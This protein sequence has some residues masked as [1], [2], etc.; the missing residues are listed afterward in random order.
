MIQLL[1]TVLR[2]L[3]A[4]AL[5][6]VGSILLTALAVGSAVLGPIFAE[7]VT[8]SYVV[9]P[10]AR[11]PGRVHRADP[12]ARAP[13]AVAPQAARPGGRRVRQP[14]TRDRGARRPRRSSRSATAPC[15]ASCPS[16]RARTSAPGWR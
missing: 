5:L 6:S 14:S 1:G 3:R 15:A 7:A 12:G 8:N 16:G 10:A 9:D 2:G 13:V 11:G 4:R